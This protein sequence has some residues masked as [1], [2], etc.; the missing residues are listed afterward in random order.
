MA[1]LPAPDPG[2]LRAGRRGTCARE[3][4]IRNLGSSHAAVIPKYVDAIL[5]GRRPVIYGDGTQRR[6]FIYVGDV[7]AANLAAMQAEGAA[8]QVLNVATGRSVSLNELVGHLR[9]A[10]GREIPADHADPVPGDIH[11]STADVTKAKRFL[12]LEARTPMGEGLR[13]VLEWTPA[14]R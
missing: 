10:V 6:D 12:G 3:C 4:A 8:G 11:D 14:T 1:S 2:E 7:V 9:D 13:R 5:A